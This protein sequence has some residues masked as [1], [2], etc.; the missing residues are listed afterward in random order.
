MVPSSFALLVSLLSTSATAWA[1]PLVSDLE[2]AAGLGQHYLVRDGQLFVRTPADTDWRP[3]APPPE[4]VAPIVAVSADEDDFYVVVTSDGLLH[5]HFPCAD[6]CE[7]FMTRWG[8]PFLEHRRRV[9]SLPFPI[10]H[11]RP[12][13]LAF[14][15]RHK[16]VALYTEPAGRD[17]NWGRAGTS[18]L[19]VLDDTGTRILLADPWLPPDFSREVPTP[20]ENNAQLVLASIAVSGSQLM[21]VTV[22]GRLFTRFDD[23]DINGGTPFFLYSHRQPLDDAFA[24]EPAD[25]LAS[26]AM[27]RLTPAHPWREHAP[28]PGR[29]SRRIAIV[30]TGVGNDARLMSVLGELE[31]QRGVFQKTVTEASWRFVAADEAVLPEEWLSSSTP[32]VAPSPAVAMGGWWRV[33]SVNSRQ[34][35]Y[36]DTSDFW[37]HNEVAHITLRTGEGDV[38]LTLLLAD[39]WTLFAANNAADDDTAYRLLMATVTANAEGAAIVRRQLG[40]AVADRLDQ[41]FAFTIVANQH[42]LV[43]VPV[44]HPFVGGPATNMLVLRADPAKRARRIAPIAPY[45]RLVGGRCEPG[46]LKAVDDLHEEAQV[47]AARSLQLATAVP[48]LAVALDALSVV[49]TVRFWLAQARYIMGFE[50]H[51]PSILTAQRLS[52]QRWLDASADD[53]VQVRQTLQQC[54]ERATTATT[55]TT[56]AMTTATTTTATTTTATTTSSMTVAQHSR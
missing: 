39:A 54:A 29:V 49:T 51:L 18:S 37:F 12:G 13:R 21:A 22:D 33:A 36:A 46:L 50:Q 2:H 27:T 30:Q 23:Y 44:G 5:A 48:P 16:N 11:L 41:T 10:S 53:Y 14:S 35:V 3:L 24:K 20:V 42:E 15:Q 45:T 26:E 8:L 17:I 56:T 4:A 52:T 32:A 6:G 1:P 28:V 55:A 25:S 9:L 38:E 31:G 34:Q 43:L 47:K 7:P 19:F 40:G